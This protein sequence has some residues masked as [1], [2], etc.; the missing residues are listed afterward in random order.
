MKVGMPP[1]PA[2]ERAGGKIQWGEWSS[3]LLQTSLKLEGGGVIQYSD[4]PGSED[5]TTLQLLTL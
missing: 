1:R 4:E 2:R 3:H 5:L